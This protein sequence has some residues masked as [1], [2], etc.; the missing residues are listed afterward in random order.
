[1]SDFDN[2][3]EESNENAAQ[4]RIM[5]KIVGVLKAEGQV[6]KF[7][8]THKLIAEPLRADVYFT[9]A[10]I[11]CELAHIAEDVRPQVHE[12]L[13]RLIAAIQEFQP[14]KGDMALRITLKGGL[15][16]ELTT[17]SRNAKAAVNGIEE[18]DPVDA[19]IDSGD[20]AANEAKA[21]ADE[22]LQQARAGKYGP[23]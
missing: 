15:Y 2:D 5:R 4:E 13:S 19:Q 22:L 18:D 14:F 20:D 16:A 3:R 11:T 21:A 12:V 23:N 9:P 8:M 6:G 17:P 1:M 10:G 7:V